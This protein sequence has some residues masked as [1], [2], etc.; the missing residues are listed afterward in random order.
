MKQ[1]SPFERYIRLGRDPSARHAALVAL[2]GET[3]CDAERYLRERSRFLDVT[4]KYSSMEKSTTPSGDFVIQ[5][6]EMM[7]LHGVPSVRL[8]YDALRF[9]FFNMDI[10][11]TESS[12]ELVVRE[13]KDEL[14]EQNVC[15]QRLLRAASCGVQ[16]ESNCAML[17]RYNAQ[18]D[19]NGFGREYAV[20]TMD[21]VNDD[22]LYPYRPHERLRHDISAAIS[23]RTFPRKVSTVSDGGATG[24][25]D[26]DGEF[27][28]VLCR[29]YFSKLHHSDELIV[30][31]EVFD[32]IVLDA[33]MCSREILRTVYDLVH[34]M[35]QS[36]S[37]QTALL[38]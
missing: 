27:E 13:G 7:P 24:G 6:F 15:Q 9:F 11:L 16:I 22:E 25:E 29:S 10:S 17:G 37:E 23:L 28:I 31:P 8:V 35:S 1:Q 30:P 5:V 2:K 36:N 12:G 33:D 34:R 18:D 19:E 4:Q 38:S 32:N 21:F 14:A 26:G 20:V 3:L